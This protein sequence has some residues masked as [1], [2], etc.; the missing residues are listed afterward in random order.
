MSSSK[1]VIWPIWVETARLERH[2]A[3]F[4]VDLAHFWGRGTGVRCRNRQE[5]NQSGIF[6]SVTTVVK[7]QYLHV[8]IA[9]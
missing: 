4:G 5:T 1:L 7:L 6:D 2:W 9:S 3:L 8:Q